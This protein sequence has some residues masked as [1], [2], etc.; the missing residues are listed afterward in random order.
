LQF[1]NDILHISLTANLMPAKLGQVM[2]IDSRTDVFDVIIIGG[3]PA[4][5]TAALMLGRACKRVLVCDTGKPCNQV[6]HAAYGFFSRDGIAPAQPLQIGRE[7]LRPYDGVEIHV[8]EVVDAQKLGDRFQVTLS[9][10][11]QFVTRKLLLATGMKDTLPPI[12]GFAELWGGSV[13]HCPYCH[14][15]EVRDQPLAIYGKGEVGFEMTLMLTGWSRDLVLCSD[16]S[17][18]LSHE[19]RQRLLNWGVQIREEK[20]ARLEHKDG[21]LTGIVFTNNEVLPRRGIIIYP[22]SSQHSHLAAKLGCKLSNDDIVEVDESKQTA[23]AGLYAVGDASSPYSHIALAV[24]SGTLAA[25]F[26]NRTLIEENLV[27][28]DYKQILT[29][30]I[31][32]M[33]DV[34]TANRSR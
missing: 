6:A 12:D 8:G 7:Q 34:S 18:E 32:R 20:I 23:I 28:P 26:I 11:N 22:Q 24:T 17:A 27:E 19:Q 1:R 31:V 29:S 5:L 25:T 15:W 9:D 3:G 2:N 13:F 14:G 33:K 10:G 16:G 21:N 30:A 4:G